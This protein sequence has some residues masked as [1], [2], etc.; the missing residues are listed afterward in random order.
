MRSFKAPLEENTVHV[1][2][3]VFNMIGKK[4]DWYQTNILTSVKL[5]QLLMLT[6]SKDVERAHRKK[7]IN[8]FKIPEK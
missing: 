3:L 4:L 8:P 2:G 7:K 6:F 1:T 5:A